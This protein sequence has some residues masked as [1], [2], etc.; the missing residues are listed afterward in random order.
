[1][2]GRW[3]GATKEHSRSVLWLRSQRRQRPAI[4]QPEGLQIFKAAAASALLVGRRSM[5][6]CFLLATC[7]SL[8]SVA[9]HPLLFMRRVL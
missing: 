7:R 3:Q 6:I 4:T 8:K 9:T 1:M 5:R 2:A